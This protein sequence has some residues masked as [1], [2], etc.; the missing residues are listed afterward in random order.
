M[1]LIPALEILVRPWMGGGVENAASVV[2][3]LG[4]VL[5]MW[6]AL[7]AARQGQLSTLGRIRSDEGQRGLGASGM[8]A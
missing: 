1:A 7:A 3:H 4:L 8:L 6:G 5:A 2:Q